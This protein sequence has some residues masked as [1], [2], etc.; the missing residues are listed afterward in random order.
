[1]AMGAEK[2]R[3]AKLAV[4]MVCVDELV[5]ASDRLRRIDAAVDWGFVR[6][7]AAPYDADDVAVRRSTRSRR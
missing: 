4:E 6:A 1:M 5:P 7:L 3:A 2:G